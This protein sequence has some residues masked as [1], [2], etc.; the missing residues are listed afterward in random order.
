MQMGGWLFVLRLEKPNPIPLIDT[1][2]WVARLS[3][4]SRCVSDEL[5]ELALEYP[6]NR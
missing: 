5:D 6:K 1:P 2:S 4:P 3:N